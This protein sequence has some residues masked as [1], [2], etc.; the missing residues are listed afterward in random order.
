LEEGLDWAVGEVAGRLYWNGLSGGMGTKNTV[1][2]LD[3]SAEAELANGASS[4]FPEARES[5]V[6]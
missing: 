4:T 6:V 1:A 3:G 5:A 2:S